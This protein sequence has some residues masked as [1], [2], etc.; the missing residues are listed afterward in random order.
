[1]SQITFQVTEDCCLRCTYCYQHNKN[2]K[3]LSFE[4]AKKFIDD[5]FTDKYFN[6]NKNNVSG[7]VW[8][9]IGGEPLMEIE[10][11]DQIIDYILTQM[12]QLEH[13]WLYKSR[14][15]IC[16]NGILYNTPKVQNFFQK[17]SDFISFGISID[18]NK[19]LHDKCRLDLNGNGSYDKAIE[20]VKLYR[21]QFN[22]NCPTK[23]TLAPENINYLSKAIFNLINEGYKE[24]HLNCIYE[25]GW[26]L[27]HA[28]IMY[29]EMKII[30]D[31][32]INNN[33]YN[34]IFISLFEEDAF[35]PMDENDNENWCGGIVKN[36]STGMAINESGNIYPC[37]RYMNSSL[38]NKQPELYY[39]N[40]KNNLLSNQ[41]EQE[42]YSL[43]SNITR[44]SQ[45]TDECF[46]CPVAKGCGWCSGY[47]YEEFGTPN[48]RATYICIMHKARALANVYYWNKLYQYLG[49]NKRKNNYLINNDIERGESDG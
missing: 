2:S 32:L 30:A 27:S 47:N 45:S 33:L 49:I 14:I 20:A 41:I 46:Y 21:K 13:P 29:K 40:I 35:E 31:Y 8:E 1:M 23:M 26:E 22:K 10:L 7:I 42:N 28:K 18:G 34:K 12:I 9:F 43:L 48:K 3:K 24:I 5:L 37:I 25:S 6:I 38:N 39:G 17:Y 16:S 44:R 11:I 15:S 19:E 4:T 36:P